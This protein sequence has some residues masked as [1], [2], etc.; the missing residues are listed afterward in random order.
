MF[1][2]PTTKSFYDATIH[3]VMPDD[4]VE[5]TYA[6]QCQLAIDPSYD[7]KQEPNPDAITLLAQVNAGNEKNAALAHMRRMRS[8]VL[9]A[10]TGISGRA[11]REGRTNDAAACDSASTALLNITSA[12]TVMAA[13]DGPSTT[14]AVLNCYKSIAAQLAA[15]SPSSINAFDSLEL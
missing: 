10:L 5:L 4:A 7:I 3:K 8:D 1:Y 12:P 6:Q 9:N 14:L 13:T 11:Q 15:T 2:S